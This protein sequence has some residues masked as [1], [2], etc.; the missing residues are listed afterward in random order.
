MNNEK[1]IF[2]V[3]ERI[4]RGPDLGLESFY[5]NRRFK[6]VINLQTGWFEALLSTEDEELLECYIE[7][8]NYYDF[9]LNQFFPP[10]NRQVAVALSILKREP[11]PI[12]IHCRHGHERTGFVIAAYRM[13]VCGWTF[14]D[15]YK[16]WKDMGCHWL[17]RLFWKKE[18]RKYEIIK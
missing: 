5:A 13:Q 4:F 6:T 7:N 12:Y 15:A 2:R 11:A 3:D 14:A 16:E 9:C 1:L 8:I 17:W 18:L 10:K